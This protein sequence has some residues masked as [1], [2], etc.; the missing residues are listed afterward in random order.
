MNLTVFA[1]P[2]WLGEKLHDVHILHL[3]RAVAQEIAA[4]GDFG[5]LDTRLTERGRIFDPFVRLD[6]SRDRTTDSCGL[7]LGIVHSMALAYGGEV[8]SG[9]NHLGALV[10]CF[11]G[12]SKQTRFDAPLLPD[13]FLALSTGIL[14]FWVCLWLEVIKIR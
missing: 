5:S 8:S 4:G 14:F 3:K 6:P 9:A 7:G 13:P 12:R 1:L 11:A 2:R 10:F